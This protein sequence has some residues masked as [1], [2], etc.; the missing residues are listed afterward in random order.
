LGE[1]LPGIDGSGGST[2]LGIHPNFYMT[3]DG[4]KGESRPPL[5]QINRPYESAEA[6]IFDTPILKRSTAQHHEIFGH[7]PYVDLVEPKVDARL[8]QYHFY[9]K[10]LYPSPVLADMSVTITDPEGVQIT[11]GW[12]GFSFQ[13][14]GT[15]G[16]FTKYVVVRADGTQESG[17]SADEKTGT[18]WVGT[19]HPGD[20]VFLPEAGEGMFVLEGRLAVVI[21]CTPS[22]GWFRLYLGRFDAPKL[23]QGEQA[24]VR[25]MNLKTATIGDESLAEFLRFRDA[26]GIHG[27]QPEYSVTPTQGRVTGTRYLLELEADNRGFAGTFDT[28]G[29][30][31][32]LPVKV[33]GLNEKWTVGKVDVARNQWFPLGVWQ[34]SAYT[35]VAP[36]DGEQSYYVGN[37]VTADNPDVFVTL[38]PASEDGKTYIEVHNPTGQD[39]DVRVSVPVTTFLATVQEIPVHVPKMSTVRVELKR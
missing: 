10:P 38:L 19:L 28:K 3:A 22:K 8:V 34:G 27:W 32:R 6:I 14:A 7:A 11:K 21:E 36:Q 1:G 26:Y 37:L 18:R 9:R 29:L 4:E 13:Y 30:P 16:R 39:L 24:F 31:Q 25:V 2:A 12:Q 35:E 17:P 5:H 15:W 23:K 33:T 20:L